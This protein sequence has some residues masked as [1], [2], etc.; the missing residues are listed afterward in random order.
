MFHPFLWDS[1]TLTDLGTLGG[2]DGIANVLNDAGDVAGLA[3]LAGDEVHHAF[4]W[5]KG[6]MNDLGTI[7]NDPCSVAHGINANGL[8]VGTSTD[9]FGTELHGFLWE[10]GKLMIDLNSFVPPASD[11]VVVD[12][13][14]IN[15]RGEIAGD[16]LLP[17]GDFHAILLVPCGSD[18]SEDDGCLDGTAIAANGSGQAAQRGEQRQSPTKPFMWRQK[19]F[20]PRSRMY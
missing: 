8:V 1:G 2:S 18:V 17:N 12:G 11:L 16:G 19:L 3:T 10:P 6:V 4:F 15:D 7:G 20:G 13:E 14:T 9:C 5:R